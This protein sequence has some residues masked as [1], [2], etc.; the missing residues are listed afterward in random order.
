[1]TTYLDLVNSVIIESG[2]E[3]DELT[4]GTFDTTTDPLIKRMKRW[5]NQALREIELERNEW[6]FKTKQGQVIIYPRWLV[7]NGSRLTAPPID[8]VFE[9]DDS[10]STFTVKNVTTLDGQWMNGNATALI[11]YLNLDGAVSFHEKFDE[12][13][14]DP[15]NLDV[16]RLRWFGRYN[17]S[18]SFPNIQEINKSSF[19]LQAASGLNDTDL[20]TGST[21]NF[22]IPYL[23]WAQFILAYEGKE[24]FGRPVVVTETPDGWWDFFPR[25]AQP[26]LLTFN[27]QSSG[28]VLDDHCDT[29]E[30][31]PVAYH[32]MIVWRAVMYYAD[33]DR[34]PDLFARAER[35]YEYYKNRA[36]ANLMPTPTFGFNRF[37]IWR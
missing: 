36:E 35:R 6:E 3:L 25:P 17:L 30:D 29:V 11:D 27:Y 26:Y 5:T 18:N 24:V 28:Q 4:A 22:N 12:V 16:F 19:I 8:S 9:G 31:L 34:Q 20:N 13:E 37:S 7:E 21:V 33:Y 32:D 2:A 23:P 1:M 15:T 14:P 10:N